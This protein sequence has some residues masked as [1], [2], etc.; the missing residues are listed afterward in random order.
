MLSAAAVRALRLNRQCLLSPAGEQQ[1]DELFRFMSPVPPVCWSCPGDPPRL[2]LHVDFD[3]GAYNDARRGRRE[4]IKGRFQGGTL[5][6][7]QADELELFACA[8][9]KDAP[10]DNDSLRM[11]ELLEHEGPLTIGIIREITGL[12]A[13]QI[14]PILHKLQQAF[15]VYEDQI[16]S[17]WDRGWYL[18]AQEFPGCDTAHYSRVE[19][20]R[21]L[22]PRF[23]Y[24]NGFFTLPMLRDYFRLPLRDLKAA[25]SVMEEEGELLAQFLSQPDGSVAPGWILPQDEPLLAKDTDIPQL[26]VCLQRNDF[27]VRSFASELKERYTHPDWEALF[28]FC[29]DGA[30]CGAVLGKFRQGPFDLE[31]VA[32]SL[33]EQQATARKQE[34]LSA[35]YQVNDPQKSPLK[36]YC[37]LP[38]R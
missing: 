5:G 22:I 3:D 8:Y 7:V 23:A 33:N 1:Y 10:M 19:A 2:P 18:L 16:D 38:L 13:K 25:V 6:Y 21:R 35:V 32:L 11:L 17:A 34:I 20:L 36:R 28:Y 4:I 31:D 15:L 26:T 12:P 9:R 29:I 37:G 24:L 30:L 14:T 27:L